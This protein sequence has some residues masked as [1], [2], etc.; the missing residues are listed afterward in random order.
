[1]PG[2]APQSLQRTPHL[3][4]EELSPNGR[5][6]AIGS[7]WIDSPGELF[8]KDLATGKQRVICKNHSDAI[9]AIAFSADGNLL[10]SGDWRGIVKIWDIE[11]GK[12]LVAFTHSKR[13]QVW[14]LAFSPNGKMLASS[15]PGGIK[16]WEVATGRQR[17]A[18]RVGGPDRALLG[19][20]AGFHVMFSPD[21][22]TLAY[23]ADDGIAR[24]WD[25]ASGTE[26]AR[27]VG[28]SGPLY[29]LAFSPDGKTLATT[30]R[31]GSVRLWNVATATPKATLLGHRD[32]PRSVAFSYDCRMLASWSIWKEDY[33]KNGAVN[34]R[35]GTQVKVWEVATGK[36]RV[37]FRPENA[38][39]YH[40]V[41]PMQFASRGHSL[42]TLGDDGTVKS[43]DLAKLTVQP[44]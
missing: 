2:S 42:L 4:V 9:N 26:R 24:L 5:Y 44:K 39:Y 6:L 31:D 3:D 1:V 23:G 38:Y 20:H 34:T 25:V 43:W 37:T 13:W 22:R 19:P 35:Y 27:L 28:H 12:E 30:S 17:A 8:L 32:I 10:A 33:K 41:L 36:E 11:S 21:G 16:L 40:R 7:A 29:D 18:I 14:S 15:S